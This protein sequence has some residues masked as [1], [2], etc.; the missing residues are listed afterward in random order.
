MILHSARCVTEVLFFRA[1][2][3]RVSA[4][5]QAESGLRASGHWQGLRKWGDA[6]CQWVRGVRGRHESPRVAK[7]VGGF[8]EG[9]RL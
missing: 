8:A 4:S 6:G 3:L 7:G 2:G 9:D 5:A 1:S